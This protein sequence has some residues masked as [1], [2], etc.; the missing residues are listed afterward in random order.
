[1][2]RYRQHDPPEQRR[3]EQ[4]S[5]ENNARCEPQ[6]AHDDEA[7][8]LD[9]GAQQLQ[10]GLCQTQQLIQQRLTAADDSG[11]RSAHLPSLRLRVNT[12]PRMSPTARLADTTVHG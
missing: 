8:A 12:A 1:M 2:R 9:L 3:A 7:F 11:R 6:L 10:P 4:P 5:A